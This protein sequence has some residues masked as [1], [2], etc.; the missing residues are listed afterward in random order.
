MVTRR[1]G[2]AVAA[3]L[4]LTLAGCAGETIV[5]V[6][7]TESA[8]STSTAVPE[9]EP[10]PDPEPT[11]APPAEVSGFY[12][13]WTQADEALR[14][15][16][17]E[18]RSAD[19]DLLRLI[20]DQPQAVWI[21]EWLGAQ[22]AADRAATVA[23]EASAAGTVPVFVLYA[24]P[25]RDCGQ[26]SAGGL[27][28][29]QYRGFVQGVAE[30][31]SGSEAWV[32]LEPDA[33]AMMGDCGDAGVRASLLADAASIL[34]AHGVEVF[35]DSGHSNW[36]SAEDTAARILQVGT[37]HLAGFSTNT[38]NYNPT[39][40]ERAWADQVSGLVGLPYIVD[41]SRNGNGSN[42]EWCNPRGRALGDV[43]RM[44]GSEPYLA[45]VWIKSPGESDGS[46]NGGPSAGAWWEEIALELARNSQ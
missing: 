8:S 22:G 15:A 43:P 25:D 6:T 42:G 17:D 14:R 2:P 46:C 10:S 30:A 7:V 26:Y 40:D 37:S 16:I 28:A 44:T 45:S 24:I 19:A 23:A 12:D 11:A 36:R 31:L 1:I 21:G 13:P 38:S 4:A 18:G 35:L 34:D 5:E 33:L 32:V 20:A 9:P 39:S 27:P 41:T 29:D 3:A